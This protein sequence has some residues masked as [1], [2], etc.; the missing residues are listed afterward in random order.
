MNNI[1]RR[2]IISLIKKGNADVFLLQETTIT[3][4]D[5]AKGRSFWSSPKVGFSFTNSM[6]RSGGL[7]TIWNPLIVEVYIV[8][9]YSSY[10]LKKKKSLWNNLLALKESF[11]DGE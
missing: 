7:L 3:S 1:K 6:G 10:E 4:M 8:N 11:N 5:E 9:I 2:R